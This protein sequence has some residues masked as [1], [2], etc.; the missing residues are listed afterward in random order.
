M[1][2]I[3][4]YAHNLKLKLALCWLDAPCLETAEVRVCRLIQAQ[5]RLLDRKPRRIGFHLVTRAC[6]ILGIWR[7]AIEAGNPEFEFDTGV[8]RIDDAVA[9]PELERLT[10]FRRKGLFRIVLFNHALRP[11]PMATH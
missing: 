9:Y 3:S 5:R 7:G 11:F 6:G 4:R 8:I 10:V 1:H 2:R